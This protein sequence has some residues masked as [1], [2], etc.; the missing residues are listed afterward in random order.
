MDQK[1]KLGNIDEFGNYLIPRRW[2]NET[3]GCSPQKNFFSFL[4]KELFVVQK[5]C[6]QFR[7]N[8]NY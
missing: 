3:N 1:M 2:A 5:T 7:S 6:Y 8:K 4:N